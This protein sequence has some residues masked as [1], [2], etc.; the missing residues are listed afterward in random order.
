MDDNHNKTKE[1]L[2]A[3]LAASHKTIEELKAEE[4][5][6]KKIEEI[7]CRFSE[8]NYSAIFNT[9]NDAIIVQDIGTF[10]IID[11]NDKACEMFCYPKEEMMG[12]N[13]NDLS[14]GEA[15]YA[16][17]V[18][19][20]LIKKSADGE[21]QLFEW[22]A[23]DKANRLF[24]AEVSLK[25]AIIGGKYRLLA[26]VRDITERKR[27]EERLKK[28]NETFLHFGIDPLQNINHLTAL[29]GEL[30]GADCALYNRL[31]GGMLYSCGQWNTPADFDAVS[32]PEGHIC[33]DVIKRQSDQIVVIRNLQET[34]YEKTDPNVHKY[35]LE[36][37]VGRVV[38]FG[39]ECIGTLCVLYKYDFVPTEEDEEIL[40][41]IASAIGIEEERKNVEDISQLS[42]FSIEHAA[43]YIFWI[44]PDA[45]ILYVNDMA[46]QILGYSREELIGMTVH[47]LDPNFPQS[48][49]EAHW[50][51]LKERKAFTFET[52]HRRKDGTIFPAE[53]TVNYLE[54]EGNEYN[55]AFVRDITER[56]KQEEALLKRDEKLE[57]LSRTSQHINAVLEIPTILRTLVAAAMELVGATGGTAGLLTGGKMKFS[58]YNKDG[59][60]VPINVVLNTKKGV[61]ACLVKTMKP[62][63][64]NDVQHDERVLPEKQKAF[65]LYNMVSVP[66]INRK[67][68]ALGCFEIYNKENKKPFDAQDI[69]MLQ[70]LAASA[71]VAL[72][73]A[74]MLSER[75]RSEKERELL[76]KELLVSNKKLK[77]LALKDAQTGLYNHRYLSEFIEPEFYRSIRYGHPLSVLMVDIDYF[78]SVNDFYGHLFGDLVIRQ[79]ARYLKRLVRR[80]DIVVRFG[81]EE[82]VIICPG[83]N[84]TKALML[85]QRVLDAVNMYDFGDK[86]HSIKIKVSVAVTSFPEDKVPR[87]VDMINL[88][89]MILNKVKEMGG[90]KVC[91]SL[92]LTGKKY[93][94]PKDIVE[95]TDVRA[96]KE[97]IE[98][99]TRKGKQNLIESI[100]AFAKTIELRD[101]YTGQHG[102]NTVHYAI[103]TARKLDLPLQDIENIREAAV[104]HDLGKVGISDEILHK[105]TRLSKKE[106]EE[107][108]KHPQIAADII[109]P[110]QFMHDIV[111][112]V[113]YHHERWDGKGYPSGLKK[114]EIPIG[115]RIIA[116]ADVYEALTSNRPYRKAYSKKNAITIVK[117]GSGTQFDPSVVNAFLKVIKKDHQ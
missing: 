60:L 18:F 40:G 77:Q 8:A 35:K 24:W 70:G 71:S 85:A 107:I 76:N 91:S 65:G 15:P 46:C 47:D 44:G 88:A 10:Q 68:E 16:K 72:E 34:D 38:K 45:R 101:H 2:L 80:Y 117:S 108:K 96:L 52:K 36:T 13:F 53:I 95:S 55:F 69:F 113:L 43:D 57:I 19:T 58:E 102:E 104:L 37:Y 63:I 22:L 73:N 74:H 93:P 39:E 78:K 109:R 103:E 17:D 75:K 41:I 114:D 12:L 66:I 7:I 56:K 111:P 83:A 87:G 86:K 100:F 90:N 5:E 54:F 115:A 89:D 23:K 51:E 50:K 14:S 64:S 116:V 92:D 112:L 105:K 11:V 82:F 29:C 61:P 48:V 30:L 110:I 20:G 99:L 31:E 59:K 32:N 9:A 42:H 84:R 106:F 79:V 62:Y 3:E 94:L 81:G 27:T 33:Y 25:R 67:G 28:I 98:K 97:K 4:I 21:P 1:E 26:I 49:W 6:H